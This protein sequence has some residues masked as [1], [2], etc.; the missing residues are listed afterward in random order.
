M[1]DEADASKLKELIG[2]LG[3]ASQGPGRVYITGGG[4]AVLLGWRSST[5]DADLKFDPEPPGVFEALPRI[6]DELSVN[7]ELASPDAFIPELPGWRERSVFIT[8]EGPV[9]FFHYDFYGQALAKLE[10]GHVRDLDDVRQMLTRGLVD[11]AKL[12]QLFESIAQ[13]LLR[14]PAIDASVFRDKVERFVREEA[15][16]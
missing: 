7:I 5:V 11:A 8:R 6:K 14:F 16:R 13:A 10:R 3:R 2:R 9:D 12:V 4:T 1:R 15:T